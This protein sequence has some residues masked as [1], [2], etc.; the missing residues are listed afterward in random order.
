MH[1][2]LIWGFF[3]SS[4]VVHQLQSKPDCIFPDSGKEAEGTIKKQI[5]QHTFIGIHIQTMMNANRIFDT[6]LLCAILGIL[7]LVSC[8]ATKYVPENEYLL[9]SVRIIPGHDRSMADKAQAYVRQRPNSK[10]LNTFAL[11][12]YTYSLSGRD[13]TK[14]INRILRKIGEAPVIY[15]RGKAEQTRYNIEQMMRNE[16]YLHATVDLEEIISDDTRRKD[17][18]YYLHEGE[19]YTVD[20]IRM[21]TDDK[22]ISEIIQK[23]A[24]ESLLRP[25]HPFSIENLESERSR[26]TSL[27]RE[28]GYYRFTK[29]YITFIADT[30]RHSTKVNLTLNISTP[31]D[32]KRHQQHRRYM[33]NKIL[34]VSEPGIFQNGA[35]QDC[36]TTNWGKHT[37]FYREKPFV[38]LRTLEDNTY[39][40]PGDLYR[41]SLINRTYNSFAQLTAMRYTSLHM[42]EYPDSSLLDCYILFEKNKRRIMS[43]EVEGTNTMGDLGAAV[44]MT[45]SDRNLF[46]GS[47]LLSLRLSWAWEAIT[48]LS[49]YMRKNYIEY[50]AELSLRLF[51][52]VFSSLI[53]M[54]KDLLQ[55]STLLTLKLNS[56]R[57]PEYDRLNMSGAMSY[58]W[59]R[60]P[61]S[62]HKLDIPG[63]NYIYVP[64]ID[65]QFRKDY[66]DSISNRNSILKYNYENLLITKFGYTYNYSSAAEN[67]FQRAVFSMRAGAECS[68]NLLSG[69][70]NLTGRKK[71]ADNK[72]TFMN[73]AYAQYIKGD[74]DLTTTVN[75]DNRNSLVVHMG[76]G[77]AYPYGNSTVLPFEKRYFTGGANGMRGW[78][79][80][81][82]GPG[83]YKGKDKNI[84]YI[85]QT[86]DIKLDWSIE[87]RSYLFWKLYSA[88]FVDAGNIWTLRSYGEQPGGQFELGSFYKDIAFSYGMGLR[89][90]LDL[91]VLRIDAGMKAVNPAYRG[92]ERYPI[93]RPD[94][95]R[96]F[97]LHFAVGYP[98]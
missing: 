46:R 30:A 33:I 45:F 62:S 59:S 44:S 67:R 81:T 63:V 77:I 79:V 21:Q 82:L 53:P 4:A 9:N 83:S 28:N 12:L 84:D 14:R 13:S 39:I 42:V 55:S 72:Y 58:I 35:V 66:L 71:N 91:F 57:R 61:R 40:E 23:R 2:K 7:L 73:I 22:A 88:L 74:I 8:S 68:G 31:T 24:S 90:K 54:Q 3:T 76:M 15:N 5:K 89:F 37:L 87:F 86:G 48:G 96:D 19:R 6:K 70:N 29:D 93:L 50:N 16:G 1:I 56:Q 60:S 43:F 26:I 32:G 27:L 47:E 18:Y 34:Y 64:W 97:A 25:G 94:F 10:W 17:T 41:Q 80:R 65:N 92:K 11:P 49:G 95:G 69:I 36:D 85:N 38:R 75:F 20:S 78:L 51:G 52:G 98:F